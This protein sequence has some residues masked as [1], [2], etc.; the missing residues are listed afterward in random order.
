MAWSGDFYTKDVAAS[1]WTE[2]F[3]YQPN[4]GAEKVHIVLTNSADKALDALE[5][6]Y[7]VKSDA[8]WQVVAN[9]AS[10]FTATGVQWP[11]VGVDD[12]IFT[13]PKSSSAAIAIDVK[14]I[15]YLRLRAS[16]TAGSDTT[17]T[18]G[19]RAR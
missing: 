13:L 5:V 6:A 19:W 15:D 14:G 11:I 8:V 2:I 9:A 16:S 4:Q 18:I 7:S 1:G 17:L 10:D 12:T 3:K